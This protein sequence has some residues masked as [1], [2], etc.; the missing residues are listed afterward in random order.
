[1]GVSAD[2]L[3]EL[4]ALDPDT[5]LLSWRPRDRRWFGDAPSGDRVT[6][7]WNARWAGTPA[8]NADN[9]RGYLRGRVVG[10][11]V[12]AHRAVWAIH[13]GEHPPGEIDH[14]N[15]RKDDNR[16]ANLRCCS[17]QQNLHNTLA[18]L[19]EGRQF[20]GV[21]RDRG[22]WAA[23]L[24]HGGKSHHIGCFGSEIEAAKAYDA[25]AAELR[26]DY[27]RTNLSMGL[28]KEHQ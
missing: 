6:A 28:L 17:R 19:S 23:K 15:G 9:G 10:E 24:R 12:L 21:Y 7:A 13:Y 25:R 18:Q 20:K 22:R 4:I 8:L 16:V 2:T 14:I 1:M 3:R 27:A 11:N 5:G 26:G